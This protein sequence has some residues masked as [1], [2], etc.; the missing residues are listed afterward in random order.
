[1]GQPAA[2]ERH[3]LKALSH[4]FTL[5]C[6]IGG[7]WEGEARRSMAALPKQ[8]ARCGLRLHPPQTALIAFRK[9]EAPQGID[10]GNGTVDFLG[11]PH[12]WSRSRR[13]VG[14]IK[15]RLARKRLCRTKKSLWRWCH[16]HHHAPLPYP[17]QQLCQ[18]VRGHL[19]SCGIRGH[20]RLLEAVRR[21]AEQ[22]W[23]YGR[24]RHSR[25]SPSNGAKCQK[26]R[27]TDGLPIPKI[28]HNS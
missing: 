22:A 15:R 16:S 12:D 13:G 3:R 24:S 4:S 10:P 26:R 1:M 7:E 23:R 20:C 2:T 9:P 27:A 17:Y 28:V 25:K 14:V 11:L 5:D 8:L 21:S 19:Q 18:K 6:V